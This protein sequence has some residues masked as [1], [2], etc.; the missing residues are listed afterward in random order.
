MSATWTELHPDKPVTLGIPLPT[1][2]TV[3]LDADDPYHALPHGE[4]GEIGIAGIGLACGYLNR[5]DL[6]E[7]GVHPGLPGHPGEPVGPDL[8]H[9]R[10]G[11]GQRRTGRSSTTA[12]R[13]AGRRARLP[14]ELDE[15]ESALLRTPGREPGAACSVGSGPQAARLSSAPQRRPAAGRAAGVV[16]GPPA[17]PCRRPSRPCRSAARR[18]SRR[19]TASARPCAARAAAVPRAAGCRASG[20]AG[21]AAA[22]PPAVRPAPQTAVPVPQAVA[23]VRPGPGAAAG[24]AAARPAPGVAGDLAAVLA[25]VLGSRAGAGRRAL[26]RRPGRRLDADGPFLRR[27]AQARRPARGRR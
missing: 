13:P 25:D 24:S 23:P 2:S 8:P 20:A 10:P 4:I 27:A 21:R 22:V 26:L 18:R 14:H 7:Q 16:R 1:Y 9:R 5:D 6:T 15:I 17:P 12:G 3:I 19:R 11:P